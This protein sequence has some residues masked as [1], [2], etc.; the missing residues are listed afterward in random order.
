MSAQC[1]FEL[2]D[3]CDAYFEDADLRAACRDGVRDAH[4]GNRPA[5]HRTFANPYQRMAYESGM[6]T[7]TNV[8]YTDSMLATRRSHYYVLPDPW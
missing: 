6:N 1:A 7:S 5:D 8:C 3:R 4:V 2:F